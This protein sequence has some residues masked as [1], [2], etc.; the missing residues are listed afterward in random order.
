MDDKKKKMG[1]IINF[2]DKK[3]YDLFTVKLV[4]SGFPDNSE[5]CDWK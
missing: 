5:G 1:R 4:D 3:A 2:V